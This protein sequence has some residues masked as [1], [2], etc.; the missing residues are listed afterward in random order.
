M[1]DLP[2][3]EAPV[4][5]VTFEM[6]EAVAKI[7]KTPVLGLYLVLQ[8]EKGTLG[9]CNATN[10]CGPFQVNRQHYSELRAYGLSE[11]A[12]IHTAWGNAL[13]AGIILRQKLNICKKKGYDWFGQVACYHS[14]TP[15]YRL[16]YRYHLIRHGEKLKR[17]IEDLKRG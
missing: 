4:N 12:I 1:I 6:I 16:T 8:Q 10:D 13:A 14:F 3:V 5:T 9:K 11:K 15:K 7:T 2:P 17:Q